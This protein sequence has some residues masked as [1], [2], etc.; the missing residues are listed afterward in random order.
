MKLL[1]GHPSLYNNGL[2]FA[3]I[4]NHLPRFMLYNGLNDWGKGRELPQFASE[5]FTQMWKKGKVQ[6][7]KK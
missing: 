2:K 5:S 6:N 1:F 4:I 3:P 7:K